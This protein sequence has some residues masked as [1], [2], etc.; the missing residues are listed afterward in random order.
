MK[1]VYSDD[2]HIIITISPWRLLSYTLFLTVIFFAVGLHPQTVVSPRVGTTATAGNADDP[3]I[4]ISAEEIS[5][6]PTSGTA[7]EEIKQIANSDF[8]KAKGGHNDNH[9]VFTLAQALVAARMNDDALKSKVADNLVSAIGSEDGGNALSLGRNLPSYVV[10][11]DVIDFKAFD[12]GKEAQFR[13]WLRT[14]R[15]KELDGRWIIEASEKRPNNWGLMTLAGRVAIA[16]YLNEP[17][18]INR[19]AQIFK[20]WLGD[21]ASYADFKYGN[22]SW[23]VDP[24]RPVGIN[25][26][27]ATKEGHSIDGVL[28]DDQR[29]GGGFK[30]PPPKENYVYE[31]LQAV[32]VTAVILN[33]QGFDVWNWQDQA[34]LR[35]YKW[36]HNE[37]NYQPTGDD[38][39]Q[40]HI[41]NFFYGTDFPAS[42][43]A[44]RGKN[45]GWTDWTHGERMGDP[46][47]G[48]GGINP[49]TGLTVEVKL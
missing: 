6:L 21:R 43:P 24:S 30:W 13:E 5:S 28:P 17:E 8:G 1:V 39:F 31:A 16:V 14:V 25:P 37:A 41:I 48:N 44:G 26:K 3:A 23:Q 36:L 42:V 46:P 34:I 49:P 12:A 9:D 11:A 38:K 7:W 20:G 15:F 35:A 4:W 47:P 18:E 29:R 22:L 27:G 45:M 10:A 33:R 40:M 19:V 32:L 2:N